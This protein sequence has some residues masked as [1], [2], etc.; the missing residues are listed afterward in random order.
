M[1]VTMLALVV[2][3][4]VTSAPS[5][6]IEELNSTLLNTLAESAAYL[7]S[8]SR[9]VCGD[10]AKCLRRQWN[11]VDRLKATQSQLL[12]DAARSLYLKDMAGMIEVNLQALKFTHCGRQSAL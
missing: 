1:S 11:S 5:P 9:I 8:D 2:A 3:A 7:D 6:N 10:E 12:N 4:A